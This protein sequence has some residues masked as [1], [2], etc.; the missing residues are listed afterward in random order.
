MTKM[1]MTS[2]TQAMESKRTCGQILVFSAHAGR[3]FLGARVFV[4]LKMAKADATME[5]TISEQA[6]LMPR[7]KIFANRTRIFIFCLL[8]ATD[9]GNFV[10]MW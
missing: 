9:G 1:D 3:P 10:H 5:R 4:A 8:L 7:R 2:E 6:K